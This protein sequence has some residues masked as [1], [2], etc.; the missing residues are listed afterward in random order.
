MTLGDSVSE[1]ALQRLCAM[2]A[3]LEEASPTWLREKVVSYVS[4]YIVFDPAQIRRFEV[5]QCL[6]QIWQQASRVDLV[7]A[8][9]HVIPVLYDEECCPDLA[10]VAAMKGL[11]VEQV[12]TLHQSATY[13]VYALGFAPGFAYLGELDEHLSVPRLPTPRRRIPAGSVAIAERQTAVYPS[14]SPAGW[15]VLGLCPV[16]LQPRLPSLLSPFKVGDEVRFEAID[17]AR[18]EALGGQLE[19]VE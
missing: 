10:I 2:Q 3:A 1:A 19:R 17:R 8:S 16:D 7:A 18:F 4:L 11:T 14:V 13:R 15:H 12:V 9:V 5:Q 6:R